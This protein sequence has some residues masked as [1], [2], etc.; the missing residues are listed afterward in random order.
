MTQKPIVLHTHNTNNVF[1]T[2]ENG[3]DEYVKDLKQTKD[4]KSSVLRTTMLFSR[5]AIRD[6]RCSMENML[7][8]TL[9]KGDLSSVESIYTLMLIRYP[10]LVSMSG[11]L[12]FQ[13]MTNVQL[14]PTY[15][16]LSLKTARNYTFKP[17][18]QAM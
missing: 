12:P 8:W 17:Y 2:F 15:Y 18:E 1:S 14:T 6:W 9:E 7:R 11:K 10:Y 4:A 3:I 13:N 5:F 16:P